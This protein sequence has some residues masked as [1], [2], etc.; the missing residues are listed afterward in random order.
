MRCEASSEL[1]GIS[2]L[3]PDHRLRDEVLTA[4]ALAFVA[5]LVRTF[6]PRIEALLEARRKVQASLDAGQRLD[7]LTETRAIRD[8]DWTIAPLPDDLQDRRVEITGP[9]DRK[10]VINALNSGARC[11]MADFED[12]CAPT[13]N[14]LLEGQ[15]NLMQAVRRT[16]RFEDGATGR[17]YRL[18]ENPA[19]LMMRPRGLHLEERHMT[20][21][22]AVVPAPLFD[23]GLY[24]FHNAKEL[25][26]R[27]SGP[28]LYLPK[29][30]HHAEAALWRDVFVHAEAA[31]DLLPGT[32]R[33][34]V[35]IETLPAAFQMDEILFALKDHIVGLNCG[36]WDYIFS[37]IKKRRMDPS[38][39]LP[40]RG[41][42]GMTQPFLRTYS[43]LLV[44]TCHRR[45][46]LAMGG[47]AAQIPIKEDGVANEAAM[48]RV[49]QDKLR[50]VKD[51][52]DG[53]W[54]AHPGLVAL[55]TEI[56]DAHMPSPNQLHVDGSIGAVTAEDL[57][58]V[59]EGPRTEAGLR[60]NVRV[61]IRYL[62]AWLG[63]NGC[64]PIDHLMEDAATAEISRA[65]VWQWL[66]HR[67]QL[68]DGRIVDRPRLAQIIIEEMARLR[69]ELGDSRFTGSC[70]AEARL[71]FESLCTDAVLQD[72]LTIPAYGHLLADELMARVS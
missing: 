61:G 28:Y 11:F 55:A 22:R 17:T 53:T 30:E 70:F 26:A 52:H 4:E 23:F 14:R 59:P 36:R 57:L 72:F 2:L 42:V 69:A 5:D 44:H 45:G 43:Q 62:E 71:L 9:P 3:D 31:L 50:E 25:V 6:Q 20:V 27:G 1:P 47:M 65:Q 63:G 49:R 38:A 35:L 18:N 64:V 10:M 46:A 39:V 40:D 56:F 21:D 41:N 54:V 58:R 68:A 67:V 32:I 12:S 19:V 51:G 60:H 33:A 24:V 15:K 7:F 37:F 29:L 34:T 66:H 8:G 16:L 13:W 48:E